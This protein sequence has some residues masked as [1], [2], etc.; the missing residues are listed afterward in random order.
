MARRDAIFESM[1]DKASPEDVARVERDLPKM[2]RGQVAE[3]W[4]HVQ[5]LAQMIKDPNAAWGSK[6]I[7][8]GAL[9]YLVSPIDAVPDVI[10]L[11]GLA[12]DVG[13]IL[14]AVN[15]L[16]SDLRNYRRGVEEDKAEIQRQLEREKREWEERQRAADRRMKMGIALVLGA[17][18]LLVAFIV[19][20][21]Q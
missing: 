16:A 10:P 1:K 17:V 9:L 12:D 18:A 6:A 3:V 4:S 11:A 19:T 2:N 5:A 7:A 15:Q 21:G 20:A 14:F 8:I 13:V